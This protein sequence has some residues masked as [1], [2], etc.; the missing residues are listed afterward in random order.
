MTTYTD[1]KQL[2]A[3]VRAA[4][5]SVS[6]LD[7]H[8]HLCPESFGGLLLWGID[9][10][11]TYH[12]LIAE[13]MRV[14]PETLTYEDFYALGKQKQAELIWDELFVKRSP[15]SEACRGVV[16]VIGKL[17]ADPNDPE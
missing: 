1:A 4:V 2:D 15:L 6:I 5:D 14:L 9:E 13:V 16:T 11:L 12:Y 17:S 10:L 8:T 7:I 3:A